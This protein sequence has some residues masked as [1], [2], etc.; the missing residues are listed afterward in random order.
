MTSPHSTAGIPAGQRASRWSEIIAA[1]YFPLDL[2]F[3]APESF[4]GTLL[5]WKLGAA[6]LSRLTSDPLVY[7]RRRRHLAAETGEQYLVTLP[8][9][10]PVRFAQCQQN[11]RCL[12]GGFI[13]ERSH[14]PYEFSYAEP[15][16]LFV[17]KV[18]G[19]L[20]RERLRGPDRFCAL[21]FDATAGVGALLAD[22]LRLVPRRLDAADAGV[23]DAV[24]RQLVDL[25]ALAIG[26]DPRVLASATST[27]REAHMARIEAHIRKH[28]GD[29]DLSPERIARACGISTRYLHDLFRDGDR[30]VCGFVRETRLR[31]AEAALRDPAGKRSIAEIAY[32]C[33]FGDQAQ[34]SRQFKSLFGLTPREARAGS[35][36]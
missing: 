21:E 8:A 20:L 16:D 22:M 13:I 30:T 9:K 7:R 19:A 3:P 23:L 15:N 32:A 14:E 34:F 36:S 26:G 29:P 6:S 17:L 27:V 33:G 4:D 5:A 10:A 11:V 2:G 31:A 12:P 28:L 1:T 18:P 24:G 25:L 35:T